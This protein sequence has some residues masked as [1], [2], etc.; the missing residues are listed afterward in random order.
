MRINPSEKNAEQIVAQF[1]NKAQ[2]KRMYWEELSVKV[3]GRNKPEFDKMMEY[4]RE[5]DEIIIPEFARFSGNLM[6]LVK[7][8][9]K[10]NKDGI[11][12]IS[13]KEEFNSGTEEGK[14]QFKVIKAIAEY[15]KT[16]I[17]QRRREGIAAA[18]LEGKYKGYKGK[19]IPN[20]FEYYNELYYARRIN[21][22]EIAKHYGV[23]RPTVYKWLKKL[24]EK[25]EKVHNDKV[26]G[27]SIAESIF[28]LL[29][30]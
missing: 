8:I 9:E 20:D 22:K 7:M 19:E 29:R 27:Q 11:V 4:I 25:A 28:P 26:K 2:V 6:E 12:L 15:E 18:K 23:S 14:L 5:G 17:V 21:V 10:L 3:K 13:E 16:L 30:P 1:Q 24:E